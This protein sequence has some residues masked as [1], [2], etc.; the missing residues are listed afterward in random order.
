MKD[1]LTDLWSSWI[2]EPTNQDDCGV[3]LSAV[4]L[5]FVTLRKMGLELLWTKSPEDFLNIVEE[6]G[7]GSLVKH[8]VHKGQRVAYLAYPHLVHYVWQPILTFIEQL[9]TSDQ[10]NWSSSLQKNRSVW[11]SR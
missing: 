8:K 1:L 7:L 9:G 10:K 6:D 4:R 5:K 3:A 2:D 11:P